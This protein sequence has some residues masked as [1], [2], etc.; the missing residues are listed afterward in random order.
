MRGEDGG[1]KRGVQ[2]GL[3]LCPFGGRSR[4]AGGRGTNR[5]Q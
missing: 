5:V 1:G 3:K 4:R 2:L